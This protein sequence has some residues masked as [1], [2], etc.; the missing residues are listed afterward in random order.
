M[1]LDVMKKTIKKYATHHSDMIIK[2]LVAERY[3]KNKNDILFPDKSK[4]EDKEENPLRNAD[5]RIPSNFHSLLVNQ[6]AAYMFTAP[7]LFDVGNNTA[8]KQIVDELGDRYA[9]TCKDL[10]INA[11]NSTVSWLHYWINSDKKFE[12]GVIDS[13][14]IIPIWSTDLNKKLIGLLRIH[15]E[16][17]ELTGDKYTIYEYWNDTVCQAF[18]KKT[19]DT[20]DEGLQ[21]YSMFYQFVEDTQTGEMV[22]TYQHGLGRVPFIPFFNNN[23]G[24]SDLDNIKSLIDTYDKVY[25][26]F[27]NDLEDIQE[28]I[29]ILSGYGGTDLKEFIQDLKKY[30]AIKVD[31]DDGSGVSSLTINIPVEAREKLLTITRKAIFEQGQGVDP[32]PESFGNASGVALKYLYSLL[33]LKAGLMET[34]F[35]LAFGEFVRAICQYIGVECKSIIQTWTRTAITNDT[36][37]ADIAQKSQSVISKKTIVKNHP[38]VKDPEKEIQQIEEEDKI[39]ESDMINQNKKDIETNHNDKKQVMDGAANK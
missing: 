20:V 32:Q 7:P 3:Y 26:G 19:S 37:L 6:K 28:I 1:D 10:C 15:D 14:Q 34:E 2:S 11:S 39:P 5:N 31:G 36:E 17:D 24:T 18:R 12:Y 23:V 29:F 35:R 38:W 33:S 27:V 25:S 16:V 13:K 8:N 21:A 4:E 30:K 22:N 9:K